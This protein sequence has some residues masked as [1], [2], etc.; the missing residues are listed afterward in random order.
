MERHRRERWRETGGRDGETQEGE[1]ERETDRDT[2]G[3]DGER[4]R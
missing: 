4:D 3:I 2:G 1:M